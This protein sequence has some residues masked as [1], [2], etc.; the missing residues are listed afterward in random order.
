MSDSPVTWKDTARA[1]SDALSAGRCAAVVGVAVTTTGIGVAVAS[2]GVGVAVT[3]I[4]VGVAVTTTGV[5]VG[6][7]GVG[8][9]VGVLVGST[10]RRSSS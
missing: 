3:T 4:G 2:I 8:V 6:G 7:T 1:T 9:T 10:E 5:C